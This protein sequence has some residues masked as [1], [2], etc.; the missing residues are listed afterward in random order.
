[1]EPGAPFWYIAGM[2]KGN[3]LKLDHAK[4]S[5]LEQTFS[6]G[7]MV[8]LA[9]IAV[10]VY[11]KGQRY[12]PAVYSAQ[13]PKPGEKPAAVAVKQELLADNLAAAGWK[14]TG[15][16]ER[17]SAEKMYEKIDGKDEVYLAYDA[18]QL[19]C[20]SWTAPGGA[21]R[22]IEVYVYDVKAPV[23]A[24]GLFLTLR[25]KESEPIELGRQGCRAKGSLYFWKSKI[26]V[27]VMVADEQADT[28]AGAQTL[29]Q[30]L[31]QAIPD[32]GKPLEEL[33][34][35]PK[36]Q[37]VLDST[38][39]IRMSA[40]GLKF[41]SNVVTGRYAMGS[42]QNTVFLTKAPDNQAA[43][44]LLEQYTAAIEADGKVLD[45][46]K[47]SAALIVA[48]EVFDAFDVVFA[49]G[50]WFGGVRETGDRE[51]AV[52]FVKTFV[53]RLAPAKEAVP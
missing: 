44:K 28:L 31:A 20:R 48:G 8:L 21:N 39:F 50:T 9:C 47:E 45:R 52:A 25:P 15:P 19:T 27:E 53:S 32:D 4:A 35:L 41:L 17:F 16:V 37:L 26:Y 38:R 2:A 5:P 22:F 18:A 3:N 33:S 46:L 29:A 14:P 10:A 30:A 23:N 51:S 12:K 34:W 11:I 43:N 49:C 42:V 24:F 13:A 6:W 1:M 40:F 7:I 36:D